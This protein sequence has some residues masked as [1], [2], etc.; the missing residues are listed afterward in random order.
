[1]SKFTETVMMSLK[2]L[3]ASLH[4]NFREG[5]ETPLNERGGKE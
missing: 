5:G 1:M 2:G 4:Q 3:D